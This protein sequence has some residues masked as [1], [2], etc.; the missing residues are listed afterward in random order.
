MSKELKKASD[1]AII[2]QTM[3][4]VQT[5][6]QAGSIHLPENYS[7]EN[8]LNLAYLTISEKVDKNKKPVL[9]T[10]T[11]ASISKSLLSMVMDGLTPGKHCNFHAYAGELNYQRE[12]TGDMA[13]V[14]RDFPGVD[15][16]YDVIWKGEEFKLGFDPKKGGRF[17]D[18]HKVDFEKIGGEIVGAYCILFFEGGKEL[19]TIM[20][21][22]QIRT[23]W[24]Q[25]PGGKISHVHEKFADQMCLKTVIKRA[26]KPHIKG[27]V[28]EVH[29]SA[30]S[31][32]D[33]AV[34]TEIQTTE[35]TTI[36]IDSE[37]IEEQTQTQS[38]PPI[39]EPI[40]E[41]KAGINPDDDPF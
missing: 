4:R 17:V 26:C 1:R 29:K 37:V 22:K 39:Q 8:A 5:M 21:M 25:R 27:T 7:A 13:L 6:Q 12:Y 18:S 41:I 20:T 34:D 33:Q 15:F 31:T 23:S 32:T 24:E 40:N 10:C 38:P 36:D 14:K 28:D 30:I 11:K 2:D 9:E 35:N 19:H 16:I 3:A